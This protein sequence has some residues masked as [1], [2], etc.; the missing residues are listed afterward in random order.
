VTN[1][2]INFEVESWIR[3]SWPNM[4]WI[5]IYDGWDLVGRSNASD[6]TRINGIELRLPASN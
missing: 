6:V 4:G 1:A 3:R 5:S 2:F